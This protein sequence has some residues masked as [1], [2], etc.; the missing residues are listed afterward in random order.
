MDTSKY[1]PAAGVVR[2]ERASDNIGLLEILIYFF[3]HDGKHSHSRWNG[4]ISD[5]RMAIAMKENIQDMYPEHKV[6][7]VDEIGKFYAVFLSQNARFCMI[8]DF[9]AGM[10]DKYSVELNQTRSGIMLIPGDDFRTLYEINRY[11]S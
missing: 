10:T 1:R 2:T 7:S 8:I 3:F 11:H 6:I 4:F 5:S 9:V